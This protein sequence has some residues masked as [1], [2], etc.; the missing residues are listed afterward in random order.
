MRYLAP[1]SVDEAVSAL[2]AEPGKTGILAGGTDLL[3]Q[4]KTGLIEP[5]LIVDIKKINDLNAIRR[6]NGGFRI[7]AGVSGAQMGEHAELARAWPGVVESVNL[8]GSTQIQGRATAAGNLCNASPAAD[9][10]PALIA[11]S[12]VASVAG[13]GG[14]REIAVED[15]IA[16]PGQS[17]LEK[18]EIVVSLFLP[19]R[20]EHAS[21]AYERF[22]PRTEMDIAVVGV[23]ISVDTSAEGEVKNARVGIGAVAPTPLLVNEAADAIVG[24]KLD[25]EALERCASAAMAACSPIN[26]KRGTIDFRIKVAG[27]L[28]KRVAK[29][30]YCRARG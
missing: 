27:A 7:G 8:I 10:V 3:V 28:A 18:G 1:A 6:E 29:R 19:S 30:A 9:S 14:T 4:M 13:P 22:I 26:D 21:D 25:E 15:F 17:V 20:P 2:A 5:D 16:A 12:A 11:A 24:T 23:G